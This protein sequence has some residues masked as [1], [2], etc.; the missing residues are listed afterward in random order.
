MK[1][2]TLIFSV[3]YSSILYAQSAEI[4][5]KITN[6][7]NESLPSATIYIPA[8]EIG[9]VTDQDGKYGLKISSKGQFEVSISYIGYKTVKKTITILGNEHLTINAKLQENDLLVNEIV[10]QGNRSMNERKIS[11]GKLN[12]APMDLPQSS[13]V[14]DGQLLEKQ[15]TIRLS[16]VVKNVTGVYQA[17]ATGGYT[18]EIG[19]RGFMF[20]SSNTFKNGVRFNNGIMPELSSLERVEVLKGNAAILFG[21][22][23]A[24]GVLNL[25]TKKPKFETGGNWSLRMGSY[26]F[27]KPSFDIYGGINGSD[28]AAYRINTTF[29]KSNSYRDRVHSERSYINPSFLVRFSETSNLLVEGDYLHDTRIPDFG[30]GA[31]NYDVA[32]VPR[33]RFFN[34]LWAENEVEQSSLTTTFTHHLSENWTLRILGGIQNYSSSQFGAARPN[35]SGK[36]IQTNGDWARST[37]KSS[38]NEKYGLGQIDLAGNVSTGIFKHQLLGGIDADTKKGRAHAFASVAYDSINIYNPNRFIERKDIPSVNPTTFTDTPV[39]RFGMYAQDLISFYDQFKLLL[40]LR[41]SYSDSRSETY[42]ALTENLTTSSANFDNAFSPRVG[43]IWQP[44]PNHSLFASYS[45]SFELNS[46][47]DLSDNALKPSYIDQYE[48]GTKNDWLDG[49]F[50]ANLTLY[51]IVNS[52]LAQSVYPQDPNHP[53]AKELAGE[54]TSKGLELDVMLNAYKGI[55]ASIGYSFNQSEYTKSNIYI[56]GSRLRYNPSNTFN[57]NVTYEFSK[58]SHLSGLELGVSA[59][60]SG[61]RKGGRSTQLTVSNDNRKLIDIPDYT[62]FDCYVGYQFGNLSLK[63]KVT[64]LTNVLSYYIHDDNAIMPIAPRQLSTTIS[65]HF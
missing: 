42:Q 46:G 21:N 33:N 11:I 7:K 27:Y 59:F 58:T 43:L 65:Y 38:T 55:S 3:A 48:L 16:D 40:G 54:L 61:E 14:I 53:N 50:S 35:T 39:N 8:L 51:Y 34:T 36:M 12:V 37:A 45:N 9:T 4:S 44:K 62:Q 5:G 1:F 28:V 29:E 60:Y 15:Q 19:A 41:W 32:K 30:T 25:V 24:G 22:V 17:G 26:Q 13:F 10:V 23:S 63:A 6:A 2:L 20:G 49:I 47:L 52:N 56:V 31:V 64:N 57:T 18:E